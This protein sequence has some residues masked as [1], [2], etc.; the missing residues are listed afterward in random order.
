MSKSLTPVQFKA[1]KTGFTQQLTRNFEKRPKGEKP[2][3]IETA[4]RFAFYFVFG[5][6][7][8]HHYSLSLNLFTIHQEPN[9]KCAKPIEYTHKESLIETSVDKFILCGEIIMLI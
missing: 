8:D 7:F 4:S 9:Q 1:R 5:M 3:I 2:E 6:M